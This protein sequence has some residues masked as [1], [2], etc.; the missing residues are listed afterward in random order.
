MKK[1]TISKEELL[2][3]LQQFDHYVVTRLVDLTTGKRRGIIQTSTYDHVCSEWCGT[4]LKFWND[5]D[6]DTKMYI[7]AE[8]EN[9]SDWN[10]NILTL[11]IV[12]CVETISIICIGKL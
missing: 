7:S 4:Y 12:D 3:F 9:D 8:I 2:E 5:K 6:E 1:N 11:H 10:E